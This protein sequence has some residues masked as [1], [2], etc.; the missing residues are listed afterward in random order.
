MGTS[1]EDY[2]KFWTQLLHSWPRNTGYFVRSQKCHGEWL[3]ATAFRSRKPGLS[4]LEYGFIIRKDQAQVQFYICD[5]KER[6]QDRYAYFRKNRSAI[7]GQ[8][9]WKLIWP[10]RPGKVVS[11]TA[12]VSKYGL[13]DVDKWDE[14]QKNMIDGM[15]KLIVTLEPYVKGMCLLDE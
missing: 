14:I 6:N 15:R 4:G 1:E 7:D 2:G 12:Q 10:N 5:G 13:D 11:I 8:F 9:P 3:H